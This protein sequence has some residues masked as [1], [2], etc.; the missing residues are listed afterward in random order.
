MRKIFT[1][2][3]FFLGALSFAG[4][5]IWI[6]FEQR[7]TYKDLNY[8]CDYASFN[9][10]VFFVAEINDGKVEAAKLR[11][12]STT[13]TKHNSIDLTG[14]EL[15]GLHF[16]QDAKQNYWIQTMPLSARSLNW[17]FF[18]GGTSFMGCSPKAPLK[19]MDPMTHTFT[20]DLTKLTNP[21][22]PTPLFM[23]K[24]ALAIF[25]GVNIKDV[26]YRI[27][28]MLIQKQFN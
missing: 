27:E 9:P 2:S 21:S 4:D 1:F 20:Y 6:D 28:Y 18:S 16:V 8:A 14:S 3:F 26:P 12:S 11:L 13:A 25:R 17:L 24:S 7:M 22:G 19:T 5:V 23:A 10:R 15:D